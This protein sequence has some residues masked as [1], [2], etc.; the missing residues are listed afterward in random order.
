MC[1]SRPPGTISPRF[2]S[3]LR[4]PSARREATLT[5]L[6]ELPEPR[7]LVAAVVALAIG[8]TISED[9]LVQAAGLGESDPP[10][11]EASVE[12]ILVS[13]FDANLPPA[14]HERGE[15]GP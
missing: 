14:V 2:G 8:W 3:S 13:L 15:V 4:S 6:V 7:V 12:R 11:L 5:R 1:P 9:W 10:S